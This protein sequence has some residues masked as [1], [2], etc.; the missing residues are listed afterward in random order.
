MQITKK[1]VLF[2]HTNAGDTQVTEN[3]HFHFFQSDMSEYYG[4]IWAKVEVEVSFEAP[5]REKAIQGQ[6]ALLRKKITS[7]NAEAEARSNDLEGQIQSLLHIG[8]DAGSAKV[9]K[10]APWSSNTDDIPF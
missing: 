5:S 9:V 1:V 3:S 7:I 10:V 8:Y 4:P 6:V 2:V